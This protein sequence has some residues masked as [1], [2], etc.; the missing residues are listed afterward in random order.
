MHDQKC[1]SQERHFCL[2][3]AVIL[4]PFRNVLVRMQPRDK[5]RYS[6]ESADY[7]PIAAL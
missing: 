6:L 7:S 4:K 5:P 3:K 1:R 2:G